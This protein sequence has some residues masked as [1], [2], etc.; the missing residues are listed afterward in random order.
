MLPPYGF[1]GPQPGCYVGDKGRCLPSHLV[2]PYCGFSSHV[3]VL[4]QACLGL[5]MFLRLAPHLQQSRIVGMPS[6]ICLLLIHFTFLRQVF[7]G[8]PGWPDT[9]CVVSADFTLKAVLLPQPPGGGFTGCQGH[10]DLIHFIY[11]NAWPELSHASC[12]GGS[13][14]GC[15]I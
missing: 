1:Q 4:S 12:S 3:P 6:F 9:S 13:P 15:H 8:S 5:T 2:S 10:V 11:V 14:Q 7:P